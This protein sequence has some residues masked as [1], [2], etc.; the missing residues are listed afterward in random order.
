MPSFKKEVFSSTG[1]TV[2]NNLS[3]SGPVLVMV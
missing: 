3:A 2:S 1:F